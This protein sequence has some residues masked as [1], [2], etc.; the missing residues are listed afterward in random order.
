M[1]R[2][3]MLNKKISQSKQIDSL[4]DDTCKLL[5]T[6]TI[7]HLDK[8][9]VFYGDPILVR[10]AIFPRRLDVSIEQMEHYLEAMAKAGLIVIFE[11]KGEKWQWWPGFVENQT[12]LR[13]DREG[14][15]FPSPPDAGSEPE[16]SHSY[17]E[18]DD[19]DLPEDYRIDAGRLPETFPP[20]FK[21][22]EKKGS[23]DGKKPAASNGNKNGAL[24]HQ[25]M[26][27]ALAKVC[28]INYRLVT[29]ELRGELNQSERLLRVEA[30][31]A[32]EDL[33]EFEKW[34][35]GYDW[36]GKKG[37]APRPTQVRER[38]QEFLDWRQKK[39]EQPRVTGNNDEGFNL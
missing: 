38:W 28:K 24:P 21:R 35:Y 31:A 27:S 17:N 20:K 32:P 37:D 19:G 13:Q 14:T 10:S 29:E 2:G 23:G 11:T 34:W 36:R 3:R 4:P 39:P 7:A 8:N 5:A 22:K 6:W 1:A 30:R 33:P 16:D 12:G 26:F 9:G 25:V 15:E 18:E